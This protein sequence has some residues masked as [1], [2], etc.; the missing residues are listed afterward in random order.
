MSELSQY[1][2]PEGVFTGLS[3]AGAEEVI[4][5]L[6]AHLQRNGNVG[7]GWADAARARE[8]E[9][10][11]GLPL[12]GG[13]AVAVP[14]TDPEH[15]LASGIAVAVLATPVDFGSMDDPDVRL[16]VRAVFALALKSKDEQIGML[17]AIVTLLQDE[18]RL[19][20]LIAAATPS[21]A[22]AALGAG[23]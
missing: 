23:K 16:P 8:A 11:T 15:V 5:T 9:L 22:R 20:N 21:E 4:G 3:P 10:P 12:G 13:I 19:R 18:A 6:A 14:H 1:L 2:V 7:P 17:Q